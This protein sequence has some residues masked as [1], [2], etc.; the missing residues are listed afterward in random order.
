MIIGAVVLASVPVGFVAIPPVRIGCLVAAGRSSHSRSPAS[1]TDAVGQAA[2]AVDRSRA[3][4][5]RLYRRPR[6]AR[7]ARRPVVARGLGAERHL[8]VTWY[9]GAA[10]RGREGSAGSVGSAFGVAVDSYRSRTGELFY[11]S[12][13]EPGVPVPLRPA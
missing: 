10:V 5:D 11:S 2:L 4:Q 9:T 3:G 13:R 7:S 6:H 12:I 1:A 8:A